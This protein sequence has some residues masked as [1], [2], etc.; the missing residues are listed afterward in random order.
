VIIDIYFVSFSLSEMLSMNNLMCIKNIIFVIE[1]Y[2]FEMWMESLKIII[3]TLKEIFIIISL[4]SIFCYDVSDIILF[5]C[6]SLFMTFDYQKHNDK[7]NTDNG[8]I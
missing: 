2:L 4:L 8:S 5:C 3:I 6:S 7:Y 1:L